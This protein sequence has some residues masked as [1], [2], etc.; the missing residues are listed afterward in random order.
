MTAQR[1]LVLHGI[2]TDGRD[3]IDRLGMAL[4]EMGFHVI[5]V[6]LRQ[7]RWW[8]GRSSRIVRENIDR[9]QAAMQEGDHVVAHSNGC[10]LAWECM[11]AGLLFG[12]VSLFSAA[13]DACITFRPC[14]YSRILNFHNPRDRALFYGSLLPG[15]RWG[16]MGRG[17]YRGVSRRILNMELRDTSSMGHS[18]WFEPAHLHWCAELVKR[19][20]EADAE[21]KARAK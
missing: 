19:H 16:G 4:Q 1:I 21:L 12:V 9:V 13:L 2:H 8:N 20:I 3:N 18:H 11:E 10:R 14:R 7:T 17:G 15:H 5:D 6:E